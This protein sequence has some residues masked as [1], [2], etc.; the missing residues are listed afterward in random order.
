MNRRARLA[1]LLWGAATLLSGCGP[2]TP[3][4]ELPPEPS[5]T[6]PVAPRPIDR[7]I[8]RP[9]E[10]KP[11]MPWD[12]PANPISR[13]TIYFDYDQSELRPEYLQL[14]RTHA[15]FMKSNRQFPV[16]LEGHTDE[17]GTRSYNLALGDRRADTV[18]RFLLAEG[19]PA[20]QADT[21]SY[22]EEKPA[23]RGHAESAWSKNRRVRIHYE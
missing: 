7:P 21:L 19:V 20:E 16:T 22:G 4:R 9:V 23:Q 5:Y 17:R 12:D 11:R 15:A 10:V 18:R 8:E 13:R 3:Q 1:L 2:T 14:L 6:R